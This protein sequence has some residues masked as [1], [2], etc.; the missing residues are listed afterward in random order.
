MKIRILVASIAFVFFSLQSSS[1]AAESDVCGSQNG[2]S[3]YECRVKNICETYKSE[4]PVYSVEEYESADGVGSQFQNAVSHAPALDAAKALYRKNI[5]NIYKCALI[6][7][8]KNSLTFLLEELQREASGELNDTVGGQ[9]DLRITRLDRTAE[10]LGCSL[11]DTQTIHN[12]LNILRETTTE[13]CKYVSYLE[14][15]KAHYAKADRFADAG[16]MQASYGTDKKV[17]QKFTT[18]EIPAIMSDIEG[19]IAEEIAHTYKVLPIAFHAYSEYENNF[20]IHFLLAIVRADF[21]ILRQ[22]LKENLMPIAQLG[23][24]VI[25]AMSY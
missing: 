23:L 13:A 16:Q 6:Q 7:A 3:M 25:G 10:T 8:Q 17:S 11:T 18:G 21:M 1:Y 20:P 15:L 4:K 5:G 9:I 24:K 22:K 12:K 19:Q 14:Y 2:F